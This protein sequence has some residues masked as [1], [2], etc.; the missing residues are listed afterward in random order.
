[1]VNFCGPTWPAWDPLLTPECSPTKVYVGPLFCV[2]PQE[3]RR[4]IFLRAQNGAFWM[5]GGGKQVMLK[6]LVS[7]FVPCGCP[8]SKF[9]QDNFSGELQRSWKVLPDSQ[10]CK[11]HLPGKFALN[12]GMLLHFS[13]ETATPSSSSELEGRGKGWRQALCITGGSQT[14]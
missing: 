7:L 1:M 14:S 13:S 9:F 12:S 4:I 3:L 10:E 6:K 8:I 2:L 5:G 11:G